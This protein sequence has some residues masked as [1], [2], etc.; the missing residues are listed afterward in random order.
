MTQRRSFTLLRNRRCP[1]LDAVHGC[2]LGKTTHQG[3]CSRCH[4]LGTVPW[5]AQCNTS[6]GC[7]VQQHGKECCRPVLAQAGSAGVHRM[8]CPTDAHVSVEAVARVCSEA[9]A[10]GVGWRR[11]EGGRTATMT[12]RYPTSPPPHYISRREPSTAILPGE[13]VMLVP[14]TSHPGVLVGNNPTD[15]T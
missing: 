14:Q 8:P 2:R 3:E 1:G 15:Q 7:E 6:L 10:R 11:L 13:R 5:S 4:G 12:G 9:H